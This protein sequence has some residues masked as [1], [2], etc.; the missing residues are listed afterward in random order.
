MNTKQE[1][2]SA[3]QEDFIYETLGDLLDANDELEAG[4]TVYVGEAESP[5]YKQ[6]CSADDVIE[7]MGE[8]AYDVGGEWA[9]DFPDVTK[10]AVQELDAL[11]L[12]WMQKHC[13]INFWTVNNV[14]PYVLTEEDAPSPAPQGDQQ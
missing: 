9:E 5:S 8:R 10:E 1:C 13:H 3:N 6:L 2:W 4:S 7:M 12:A 14:K 11:L